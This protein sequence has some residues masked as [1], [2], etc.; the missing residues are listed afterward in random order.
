MKPRLRHR[1]AAGSLVL[2]LTPLA[3]GCATGF[4]AQTTQPYAPGDGAVGESGDL[5]VRGATLVTDAEAETAAF[6][7]T[8]VNAGGQ[9]DALTG[10]S[11]EGDGQ[12]RLSQQGI[13]VPAGGATSVG[14]TPEAPTAVLDDLGDIQPGDVAEVTLTF[15]SAAPLTLEIL[16]Q[17]PDGPYA[18]VAPTPATPAP[19]PSA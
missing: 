4:D 15:R 6:V 12:A 1:L 8:L 14:A 3:S 17:A 5:L 9:D 16:V 11:L 10:L 19:T 13:V 7:G 2:A 18:T